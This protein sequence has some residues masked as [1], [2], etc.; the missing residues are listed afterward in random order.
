MRFQFADRI[1]EMRKRVYARG[2]KTVSFEEGFLEGVHG[3]T[4]CLPRMLLIE[5]AAQLVSWLVL[6]STD[7]TKIPLVA[8]IDHA[9]IE[10]SVPCGTV[11]T[12]EVEVQSWNDE[13]AVVNCR[14]SAGEQVI[15]SGIRC[16]CTFMESS[17]LID[18]EEMTFRFRE[19]AKEA[20]LD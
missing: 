17:T 10:R 14:A 11:L 19:L 4:G 13:G 2:V 7:F 9:A 8:K 6:Y 20:Q 1:D 16:L 5:C 15:A 18:P 3:E 12:L